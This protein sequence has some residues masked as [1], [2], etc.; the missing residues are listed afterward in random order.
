MCRTVTRVRCRGH[1]T[2]SSA[3]AADGI[4]GALLKNGPIPG[5]QKCFCNTGFWFF[6]SCF[7][8][9]FTVSKTF[10]FCVEARSCLWGLSFRSIR[11]VVHI[12]T[13]GWTRHRVCMCGVIKGVGK[14]GK[15][16]TIQE[17]Y[18]AKR[19]LALHFTSIF[20][21]KLFQTSKRARMKRS[22]RVSLGIRTSS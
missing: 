20:G 6:L 1:A 8:S 14:R 22:R 21:A 3:S 19:W 18:H 2:S 16:T 10:D 11:R 4:I 13:V 17:L 15:A 9:G 5:R 12:S 7:L